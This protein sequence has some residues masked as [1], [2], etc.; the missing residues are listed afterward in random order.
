LNV[1]PNFRLS[2]VDI[3]PF[4]NIA[5]KCRNKCTFSGGR[6]ENWCDRQFTGKERKAVCACVRTGGCAYVRG[7]ASTPLASER[8]TE[9]M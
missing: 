2:L 6:W 7:Y 9:L 8:S 5:V 1:Q 4:V 3:V